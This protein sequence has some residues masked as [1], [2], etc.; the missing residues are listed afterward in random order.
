MPQLYGISFFLTCLLC[1]LPMKAARQ[2]ILG[3]AFFSVGVKWGGRGIC[4]DL[5]LASIQRF[6]RAALNQLLITNCAH[7]FPTLSLY[8]VMSSCSGTGSLKLAMVVIFAS[9]K[10]AKA[11]KQASSPLKLVVKHLP[12]YDYLL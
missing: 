12:P 1:H 10:S 11:M 5:F 7:C 9:W 4:S 2:N 8:S 6:I 3:I